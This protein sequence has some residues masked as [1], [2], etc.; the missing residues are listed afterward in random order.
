MCVKNKTN[1]ILNK[2]ELLEFGYE[3][4]PRKRLK[5]KLFSFFLSFSDFF[6]FYFF[7][8]LVQSIDILIILKL[9]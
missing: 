1:K 2:V 5:R 6:L 9:V 4:K 8:V 7:I 3:T